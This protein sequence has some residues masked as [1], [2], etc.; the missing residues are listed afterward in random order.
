MLRVRPELT[1]GPRPTPFSQSTSS[2]SKLDQN[3]RMQKQQNMEEI[4]GPAAPVRRYP[5]IMQEII[6]ELDRNC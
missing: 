1:L 3:K 6:L 2:E 4:A 5:L